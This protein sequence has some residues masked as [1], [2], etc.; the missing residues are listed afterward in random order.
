MNHN[1]GLYACR[2]VLLIDWLMGIRPPE[3]DNSLK[4]IHIIVWYLSKLT[5]QGEVIQNRP[6][7]ALALKGPADPET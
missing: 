4:Q 7:Q 1:F 3:H 5:E 2:N 6:G